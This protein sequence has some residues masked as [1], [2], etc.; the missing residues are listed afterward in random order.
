L[1]WFLRTYEPTQVSPL[2]HHVMPWILSRLKQ[3]YDIYYTEWQLF[4]Y[5]LLLGC[6]VNVLIGLFSPS[7]A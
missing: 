1:E 6:L 3:P 4:V 5:A 2:V 7:H